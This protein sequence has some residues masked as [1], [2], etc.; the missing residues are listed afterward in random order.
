M[1][2]R[3]LTILNKAKKLIKRKINLANVDS[4]DAVPWIQMKWKYEMKNQKSQ[5]NFKE[6]LNLLIL[7]VWLFAIRID[8]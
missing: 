3:I 4:F 7:L 2:M 1:R 8:L 6:L 5:V